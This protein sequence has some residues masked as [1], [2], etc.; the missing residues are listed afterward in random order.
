MDRRAFIQTASAAAAGA[1][2]PASGLLAETKGAA[3]V[4]IQ[5]GAVSFVDEGVEK[6]LDVFEQD[7]G[8]NTLFIATFTYGRGIAGRQVPSQP[9]PDHGKQQYDTDTFHGGCYTKVDPKYF[10]GT[11]FKDFRAP[12][13]GDFDVLEAVL[14]AAKKRGLKTICWFEDVFRKDLPNIDQLQEKELSGE[15]A[16]TCC[17]N[18]PHYRDWLLGMVENWSR[19]YDVDGIMWGSER[20]GALS[21]MLDAHAGGPGSPLHVTCFCQFCEAR[22]KA[23]GIN[24]ERARKGFLE[25]AK[26]VEA[27]RNARRPADG[28][29]VS[30]WRLLLKYPEL[31]AWE[32]L[33]T[34]S[35]RDTYAAI[36][37][38]VKEVKPSLQVGWHIWHNNSFN[39]IYRAEQD[40][41]EIAPHSDFLKIVIY[42]NCGGERLGY[43]IRNVGATLYADIPGQ[44]LLDFHNRVLNYEE[45]SLKEI[46]FTGLSADYVRRET[47]RAREGLAG[48]KTLLWPGIDIDIPTEKGHSRC[49]PDGVRD[50]TL[51]AFQSGADGVLLSRKYS[52]MRL[53]NLRAAGA[54]V[55]Q[56]VRA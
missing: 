42:N 13:L 12:D 9:L 24:P 36:Y 14:P 46:P 22:A 39:P 34:Q 4:G 19:L 52:E 38:K 21:N 55:R 28:Y 8:V 49:S 51:A 41:Q 18:N 30:F 31:L 27:S 50:A 3:M 26:F 35:L 29:F 5:V 48:T 40:L 17:F 32:M 54:A 43:Y 33:W 6:C 2:V 44:E 47:K 56:A 11:A 10:S 7:G 23:A 16:G 53:A 37:A 45:K 20:Q 25:L 15:N 1:A